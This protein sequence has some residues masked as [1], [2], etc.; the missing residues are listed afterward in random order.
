MTM[1]GINCDGINSNW[2]SF[3]KI[4]HDIKPW[5]WPC[6]FFLQGT[7]LPT[8]QAFKSNTNDYIIFRLEREKS[9]GGGLAMGVIEDLNPILIR[10]GTDVTEAM[11]VQIN[12]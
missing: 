1:V 7:K 11:S 9:A 4:F 10:K 3:N 2:Q 12:I 5:P 6:A 8:K